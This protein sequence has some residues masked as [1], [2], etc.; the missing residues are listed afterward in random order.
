MGRAGDLGQAE[1]E[2]C[3]YVCVGG[4]RWGWPEGAG[5]RWT[6]LPPLCREL[7][8][9][10]LLCEQARGGVAALAVDVAGAGVKTLGEELEEVRGLEVVQH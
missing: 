9:D 3:S 2:S 5:V 10:G 4:A 7:H 6:W 1:S 8:G